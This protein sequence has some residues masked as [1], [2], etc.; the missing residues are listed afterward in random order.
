MTCKPQLLAIVAGVVSQHLHLSTTV[1]STPLPGPDPQSV[2]QDDGMFPLPRPHMPMLCDSLLALDDIDIT[3]ENGGT[4]IANIEGL[5]GMAVRAQTNTRGDHLPRDATWLLRPPAG[6]AGYSTLAEG[7]A[8]RAT[9]VG[10]ILSLNFCRSWLR[11]QNN[12]LLQIPREL[13][14]DLRPQLQVILDQK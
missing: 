4:W 6:T 5:A 9:T 10:L 12:Q 13:V 14:L 2:H 1:I 11:T 3:I 7:T 8:V